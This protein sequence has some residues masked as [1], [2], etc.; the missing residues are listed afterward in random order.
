MSMG[1]AIYGTLVLVYKKQTK[2]VCISSVLMP[3]TT[4]RGAE[5]KNCLWATLPAAKSCCCFSICTF[6]LIKQVN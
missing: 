6:V 4:A 2:Q 5:K 1:H 3:D